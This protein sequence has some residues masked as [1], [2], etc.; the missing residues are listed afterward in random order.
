MTSLVKTAGILAVAWAWHADVDAQTL[1]K[2]VV[3]AARSEQRSFDAPAA[4]ESVD[5][6]TIENAGPQVNLSES[7]NR[8]PGLII[9][10]RQNYAQDL[11]VSIRG[12]GARSAFGIRGVRVLVDGIPATT[13]D[14][15]GQGS[16]IALTST[17]RIEVLRG[18]LALLYGNSAAGVIQA[19]TR[20]AP[21]Q[22]EFLAQYY[23]G[24]FDMRR[25][26]WQV[27]GRAG[28]LG[29]VANYST[30][31]TDGF[32][33]NSR[34]ERRQFNGK[35]TFDPGESTR[36]NVV[37]NQFDM[38][39]A[40]DPLGLTAAQAAANPRMTLADPARR[41]RKTVLQNQVGSSLTQVFDADRSVTA[42]AY[43][44]TRDNLQF[45]A[46]NNWVGLERAYF[47]AGLQYNALT[48]IAGTPVR[49]VAGY[50]FDRSQERRQGG[51]AALGEKAT[52][53]RDE[54]NQA[55][56][57]DLFVQASALLTDQIS[58]VAGLRS[59]TV[60]FSSNDYFR[61]DGDGSGAITY[62]ATNPVAGLTWHASDRLNLYANFGKG[63]ESPT[64]AEVAYRGAGTPAFNTA[65]NAS[66]SRHFELG[67]KWMPDV[68][69]R[70]D[71]ALYEIHT[72]DEIVVASSTGGNS[73]F[74]NA[75]GT[76]RRGWELAGSLLLGRHVSATLA[77][78]GIDAAFTQ[79]FTSGT[80]PTTVA[81][82]NRLPGIPRSFVFA[83]LLWSSLAIGDAQQ[84]AGPGSRAGIELTHA[85]RRYA[86]DTNTESAAGYTTLSAKAS[87]GWPLGSGMLTAYARI[88]NL[89]DARYAGSLI[90]NQSARQFYEPAPGPNWTLGLRLVLPL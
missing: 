89:A 39:L 86:N 17:E 64:L 41:V 79:T 13:P 15:Q 28:D 88:D 58:L 71:L 18:P 83:E 52:T 43:Y 38:P 74:K 23:A 25:A 48:R 57:S 84:P 69:S 27:A 76:A 21:A 8:I 12:F 72:T 26:D 45:Q 55:E 47:G 32:R 3:S 19:F 53:S 65:L 14:G 2:V 36:M 6:D 20:D 82:G 9:L 10:N 54:D 63:F 16:S 75:P 1:D 81:A 34:T 46:A 68:R 51:Q 22:P 77:A 90:V 40:Q 85:G 31:D 62:R 61:S 73:T 49:W 59:S 33:D 60:R 67:A 30:F 66:S 7:L 4:I 5:R 50:E 44:G 11:Q 87:H 29:L 35:L 37:F 42:R 78:S 80:P 24:S 56:N 70:L